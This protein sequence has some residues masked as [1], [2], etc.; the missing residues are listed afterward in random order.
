[1]GSSGEEKRL[2]SDTLAPRFE[3]RFSTQ[4]LIENHLSVESLSI[5][6]ENTP[7]LEVPSEPKKAL[8][9]K[10][11]KLENRLSEASTLFAVEAP[12]YLKKDN[13][14]V[15]ERDVKRLSDPDAFFD[16]EAQNIAPLPPKSQHP[17]VRN[18]RHKILGV[19]RRLF[20]FVFLANLAAFI[21]YCYTWSA[22]P[23]VTSLS[24]VAIAIVV[25]LF[26]TTLFRTDYFINFLYTT[27]LW[28]PHWLPLFFRRRL[29]KVYEF[30]GVHSGAGVA[31]AVWAIFFT[32]QI[33]RAF[34]LHVP[35]VDLAP[36]V[37][38]YLLIALL[39][40]IIVAAHPAIRRSRHNHFE[41]IHRFC[42]WGA[43]ALFWILAMLLTRSA[44]QAASQSFAKTLFT[45]PV[46]YF[47]FATTFLTI[48]PWLHLRHLACYAQVLSPHA[49]RLYFP[50]PK[51][52]P[53][54]GIRISTNPLFE[55]HS[56][57]AIPTGTKIG[58]RQQLLPTARVMQPG[59]Q[60]SIIVSRAGDWTT[61]AISGGDQQLLRRYWIR[62]VPVRGV[63]LV[64]RLFRRAVIVTT[65][66][67]IGPA[68]SML[69][70]RDTVPC[71]LVWSTPSPEKTYGQQVLDE[72][73]NA[74]PEAVIWD[75]KKNGRPDMIKLTWEAFS[76]FGAEA[77]VVISNPK[78]TEAV[79]YGM[80][81][82]GVP[83]FGP[84]FD[85]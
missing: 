3:N 37:F 27:V 25:N 52:G 85:S 78:L 8:V 15:K 81:S 55:W 56:F 71:R 24:T 26:I 84:I 34:V 16:L 35:Y 43:L 51:M 77:V 75:T 41:C 53:V 42:G 47:L 29:A 44:S 62:G 67:G 33:T 21:W 18:F 65:G 40:A 13:V 49:V 20:S 1:M 28:V 36:V 17:V 76:S 60:Y 45:G 23:T 46:I 79:V 58:R 32:V 61:N 4:T 72:V 9:K 66:S 74:D 31:T 54:E 82:R 39:V 14:E 11:S 83:A 69:A 7:S 80:E 2:S 50:A 48:L 70:G 73:K 6:P 19:Y 30:G 64:V 10:P 63:A 22:D 68:L 57:A 38:T 5:V 12:K 59:P